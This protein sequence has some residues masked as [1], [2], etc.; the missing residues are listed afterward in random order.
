[1]VF[2]RSGRD[3]D[4]RRA[5]RRLQPRRLPV[6]FYRSD[7]DLPDFNSYD[8]ADRTYRYFKGQPLWEFGYGL[9]YTTFKYGRPRL[10]NGKLTVSVRNTGKMDGDEVVQV[11]VKKDEDVNGPKMAL[12]GFRRVHIKAGQSVK[13]TIPLDVNAFK[14]YDE[15]SGEMAATPGHFTVYCG[16]SSDLNRLRSISIIRK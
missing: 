7:S 10:S 13:V 2:R 8:M 6:T 12:R 11:Y 4:S 1:M 9:S 5:V 16:P 15:A 3:C 14:T